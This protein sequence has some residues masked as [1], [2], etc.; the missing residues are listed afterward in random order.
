[1]PVFGAPFPIGINFCVQLT[2]AQVDFHPGNAIT[3]PSELSPLGEQRF[4]LHGQACAGIGCPPAGVIADILPEVERALVEQQK[5]AIG[6]IAGRVPPRDRPREPVVLHTRDLICVCLDVYAVGHF[7]WG[8]VPG[9]E[10]A[11]LKPKLD[12]IEIVDL[13]PERL[14]AAIECYIATVLRLGILPRIMVPIEKMVFDITK[15]AAKWGLTLGK[16]VSL[17]PSAA[18][19]DVPNNPAVEEDQLKVFVKLVVTP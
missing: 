2:K 19:G 6:K 16:Q 18:P 12:G 4:A 3:L 9:S 14:E 1:L 8:P 15:Q 10:Q 11:W 13:R 7:E 5:L 17:Q